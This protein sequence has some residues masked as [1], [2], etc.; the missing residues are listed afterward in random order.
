MAYRP[1]SVAE[2]AREIGGCLA[3]GDEDSARRLSFHLV[4]QYEH[5]R[6]S[7]RP[8]MI[9]DRPDSTGDLRYDALLAGIVELVCAHEDRLPPC[10][11]EDEDRF[12]QQWWFVSG[13]RSLHA[14]AIVHSPISLKRRGVFVA[15]DALTYA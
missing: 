2:L 4:E 13:L 15:E 10:W 7:E 12:L 8:A 14:N 11:V 3:A 5:A 1:P 6:P 9:A